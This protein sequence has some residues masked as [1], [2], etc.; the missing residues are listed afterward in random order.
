MLLIDHPFKTISFLALSVTVIAMG[1]SFEEFTSSSWVEHLSFYSY[2]LILFFAGV[3]TKGA[4]NRRAV[5]LFGICLIMNHQI[6]YSYL[7]LMHNYTYAKVFVIMVGGIPTYLLF[8]YYQWL[9]SKAL[10]VF[11]R[12]GVRDEIADKIVGPVGH[13]NLWMFFSGYAAL[14]VVIDFSF[15]VYFGMYGLVHGVPAYGG[16]IAPVMLENGHPMILS[17][18]SAIVVLIDSIFAILLTKKVLFDQKR[19]D[20]L[21]TGRYMSW[22][23]SKVRA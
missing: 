6:Y 3:Y 9:Q 7:E 18:Y 16:R 15:S 10:N 17:Y 13:S 21:G 22:D 1:P 5:L 4:V 12:C 19:P 8:T 20:A 2:T 23:N 14:Y 11:S